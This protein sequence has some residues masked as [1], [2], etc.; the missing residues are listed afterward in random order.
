MTVVQ[1]TSVDSLLHRL[2]AI[3]RARALRRAWTGAPDPDAWKPLPWQVI[4]DDDEWDRFGLISGRGVGKTDL[5]AAAMVAHAHGPPCLRGREPHRMRIIGP[6]LGDVMESCVEGPSGLLVH[7]PSIMVKTSGH[8]AYALWPNGARARLLG[9]SSRRDVDRLRAAGNSDLDWWE[10]LAAWPYLRAAVE[11][12]DLGLRIGPRPRAIFSTTPKR[13]PY[14][15][16]LMKAGEAD[17]VTTRIVTGVSALDNPYTSQRYKDR[18]IAQYRGTALYRQEVLG[19]L[20]EDVEGALWAQEDLDG[21]KC[22]RLDRS[23]LPTFTECIIGV[24]PSWGTTGDECGIVVVAKGY[25]RDP[26]TKQMLGHAYVLADL[27]KRCPTEVWGE[28]VGKTYRDGVAPH[29]RNRLDYVVAEGNYQG[30]QV[31]NVMKIT[32]QA[33]NEEIPFRL[34][35]ASRGKRL[36]AEPVVALYAQG[37]VHHTAVFEGLE[38][39]M[40]TWVPPELSEKDDT[41]PEDRAEKERESTSESV[42]DVGDAPG[43]AISKSPDRIDALVFAVTELL[44]VKGGPVS[45]EL[46]EARI[47]TRAD[48]TVLDDVPAHMRRAAMAQLRR[49]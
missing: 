7:D 45:V 18:L 15:R 13:R 1:D 32:A 26:E 34:V 49:G 4:P 21:E 24:D 8:R 17:P 46:S 29:F 41:T 48:R 5:C 28:I 42:D 37:R 14:I 38:Q 47:P 9:V 43:P 22:R 23:L 6:T 12:A 20:L 10:E 36:R 39:Q 2:V 31:R 3:R 19:Q 40:V 27:S 35:H 11:Q 33:L 44:L 30:E 16:E 25:E